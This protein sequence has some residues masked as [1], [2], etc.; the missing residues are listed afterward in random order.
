MLAGEVMGR[1]KKHGYPSISPQPTISHLLTGSSLL[2]GGG[3]DI[4]PAH[5]AADSCFPAG[6]FLSGGAPLRETG[7][8]G[9][10][11]SHQSP[12]SLSDQSG[13]HES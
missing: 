5:R 1:E 12:L 6:P 10:F 3:M 11:F 8:T 4:K 2:V 13:E 7:K 9:S